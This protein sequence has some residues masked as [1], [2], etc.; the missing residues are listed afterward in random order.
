MNPT[1]IKKIAV[2]MYVCMHVVIHQTCARRLTVHAHNQ[3]RQRL[4]ALTLNAAHQK[5]QLASIRVDG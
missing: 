5:M 1:L 4:A 2:L 3:D